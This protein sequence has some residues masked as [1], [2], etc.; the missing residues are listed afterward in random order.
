MRRGGL[1]GWEIEQ[2][3][4]DQQPS[5]TYRGDTAKAGGGG[6]RRH[7]GER[8]GGHNGMVEKCRRTGQREKWAAEES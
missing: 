7:S 8:Q 1:G 6:K 2:R 3:Q 5:L 4:I